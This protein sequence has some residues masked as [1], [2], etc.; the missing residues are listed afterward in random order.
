MKDS[1]GYFYRAARNNYCQLLT[2]ILVA[3]LICLTAVTAANAAAGPGGIVQGVFEYPDFKTPPLDPTTGYSGY[4][5]DLGG[6]V[7]DPYPHYVQ[8][9]DF[10]IVDDP[11]HT[12]DIPGVSVY[13]KNTVTGAVTSPVVTDSKGVFVLPSQAAGIYAVCWSS[14]TPG[15]LPGCANDIDTF[16]TFDVIDF[17]S[18]RWVTNL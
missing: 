18:N 15:L 17:V 4:L 5:N 7:G 12:P 3:S 6:S 2:S 16:N 9:F 10:P 13:L 1:N 14:G 11:V 8:T